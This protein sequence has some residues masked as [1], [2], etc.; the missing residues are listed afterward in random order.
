MAHQLM[1]PHSL[2]LKPMIDC[3]NYS[4]PPLKSTTSALENGY[5]LNEHSALNGRISGAI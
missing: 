5:L 4:A 2:V 1:K 3:R